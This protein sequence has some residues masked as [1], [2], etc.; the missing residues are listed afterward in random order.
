MDLYNNFLQEMRSEDY[1]VEV[2][3]D[4]TA[5]ESVACFYAPVRNR[6]VNDSGYSDQIKEMTFC[7][8]SHTFEK[9]VCV[10]ITPKRKFKN[11]CVRP[12]N[13]KC[14]RTENGILLVLTA[15]A[16]LSVEFDGD[17][18][19]NLFLFV[20]AE[21]NDAPDQADKNVIYFGK[22]V[23]YAD[24]IRLKDNE[25]L[26]LEG[27]ALVYG[28]VIAENANNI[29]I[30]GKGILNCRFF[31]HEFG[32]DR[33]QAV[34]FIRCNNVR[35]EDITVVDSPCWTL[36]FDVCKNVTIDNVKEIC[37]AFNSD[38]I[39]LSGCCDVSMKNVFFR[40]FD[41]CISVKASHDGFTG[42]AKNITVENCIFWAD[43]AH[44]M[45]VGPEADP[46]KECVFENIRFSDITV[47][48]E[49]EFSTLFQGVMAL[50]CAD[51]A[52]M[53]NITF[54]NIT[55]DRMDYGR[56]VSVI[57]TKA[58]A[59][60]LGKRIENIRFENIFYN[61]NQIFGNR[62]V[63]ADAAHTVESVTVKDMYVCGKKE[64]EEENTFEISE[65]VNGLKFE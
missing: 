41:D 30:C 21:E 17:I 44:V 56:L 48:Q 25:T 50:F 6:K 33:F 51:N 4:G 15:P 32:K 8:F 24:E 5:F 58:Y 16:K 43:A 52:V 13:G 62:I 10:K 38:G 65:F 26:Y 18:F 11:Y 47:L 53:R 14:E 1:T 46:A 22:G 49:V 27:G 28:R 54:E 37:Q 64:T 61:G 9:P 63:G 57:Y 42:D 19:K 31:E 55:V 2:F 39:D 36:C 7:S 12:F 35:V 20:E 60:M 40:V 45:L 23:H 59:T 34:R 3:S 29:R